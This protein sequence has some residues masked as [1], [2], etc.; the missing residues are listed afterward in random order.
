MT[1]HDEQAEEVRGRGKRGPTQTIGYDPRLSSG[2]KW[3]WTTFG[4]LALLIGLGTYNKISAM[5][6]TL[7]VAVSKLETQGGQIVDLRV[8]VAK[9]R[10]EI[11]ALRSQVYMLEGKTLRGI[12]E[13][14]HG[15]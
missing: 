2:I 11:A 5:N 9:Q 1:D 10:D 3:V 8:E 12:A 13:A 7:I 4:A 6:E 14:A 15:R